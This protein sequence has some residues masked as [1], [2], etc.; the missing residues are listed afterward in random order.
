MIYLY[1]IHIRKAN[2][3]DGLGKELMDIV[4]TLGKAAR[5]RKVMLTVF[6][7]NK[8]ACEF[9]RQQGYRVDPVSP[10]QDAERSGNVDFDIM[11][12]QITQQS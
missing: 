9:Y 5:M 6:D 11:F 10:S 4:Y 2:Q 12:K 1:E 7:H 3:R 8:P